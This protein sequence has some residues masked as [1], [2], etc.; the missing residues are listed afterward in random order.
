MIGYTSTTRECSASQIHPSLYRLTK[1]FF[2]THQLGD[3]DTET[4]E[5]CETISEKQNPGKLSSFLD[6]NPDSTIHLAILLTAEWLIWGRSGDRSDAI[7]TGTKLNLIR[8]KA[9]VTKRTKDMQLEVSG[10]M[11]DSK[12]YVLGNLGMGPDLAAQK[13]CEAIQRA[14]LKA[15]P[16]AKRK[17]FGWT[18]D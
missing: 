1:E 15:N 13:F 2:Q 5:C 6:G 12:E 4:L 16:P 17:V 11:T 18:R 8:V 10:F 7:V 14:V 9:F 3:L